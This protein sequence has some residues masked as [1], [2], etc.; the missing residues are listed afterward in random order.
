MLHR[1]GEDVA[2]DLAAGGR[3]TRCLRDRWSHA[4]RDLYRGGAVGR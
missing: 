3:K 4:S 2:D 1:E